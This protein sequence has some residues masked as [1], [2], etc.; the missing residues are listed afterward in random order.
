MTKQAAA[1]HWESSLKIRMAVGV[2]VV[3]LEV[4]IVMLVEYS[5]ARSS[6]C[7]SRHRTYRRSISSFEG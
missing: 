2:E 5:A 3:K 4:I 1:P 7:E 6:S